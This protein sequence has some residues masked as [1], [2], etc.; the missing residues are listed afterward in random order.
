MSE[1]KKKKM[2]IYVVAIVIVL[3]LLVSCSGGSSSSSK[4][5][6]S[7]EKSIECQRK[8]NTYY[9][10]GWNMVEDRCVCKSR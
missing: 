10:C 6:W 9:K 8:S 1:E 3:V 7:K 4:S 5:N 2:A